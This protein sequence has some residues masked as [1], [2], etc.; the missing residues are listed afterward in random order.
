M[1]VTNPFA[2]TALFIPMTFAASMATYYML[3]KPL[4]DL[5]RRLS[6]AD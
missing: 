4:I 2:A 6:N 3:E 1:G 5:G